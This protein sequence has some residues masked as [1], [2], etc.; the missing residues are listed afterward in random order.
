LRVQC[1]G[2]WLSVSATTRPPRPGEVNGRDYHFVSDG[3]FDQMVGRGELLEWARISGH[4]YGTPGAPL[5]EHIAAG[6]PALI[7]IDIDGATQVRREIPGALLV[8]LTTP[9]RELA[10]GPGGRGAAPF[11][12]RARPLRGRGGTEAGREFDITL[13]ITSVQ[14]VCTQLVG[15]LTV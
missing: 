10:P 9:A 5:A 13:V 11:P 1:P 2:I 3:D 8:F 15:L 7:G 12:G 6:T 4:R 14:D